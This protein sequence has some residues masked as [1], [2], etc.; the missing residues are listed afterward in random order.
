MCNL[1]WSCTKSFSTPVW[2][3]VLTK[4]LQDWNGIATCIASVSYRYFCC[5]NQHDLFLHIYNNIVRRYSLWTLHCAICINALFF[6]QNELNSGKACLHPRSDSN[7]GKD[8]NKQ[9]I[10]LSC[11]ICTV[12]L[13]AIL[14]LGNMQLW[15]YGSIN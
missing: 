4:N 10:Y 13:M 12:I 3:A 14:M 2:L 7:P 6:C 1:K 15:T 11:S 9:G 5:N 8:K